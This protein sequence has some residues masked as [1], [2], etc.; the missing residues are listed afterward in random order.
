HTRSYGDW[1][2]DVCSSDLLRVYYAVTVV[3]VTV[4]RILPNGR[5]GTLPTPRIFHNPGSGFWRPEEVVDLLKPQIDNY[6]QSSPCSS[7][8]R[9]EERRVGKE[10]RSL[11]SP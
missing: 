9:S 8:A 6:M 11:W 10:G 2:S 5:E 4:A 7:Q 3:D 1:S